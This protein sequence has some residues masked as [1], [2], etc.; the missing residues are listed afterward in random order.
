MTAPTVAIIVLLVVLNLVQALHIR[1]LER[2]AM[3]ARIG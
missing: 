3:I 1:A 2:A